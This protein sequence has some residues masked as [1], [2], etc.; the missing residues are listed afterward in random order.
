MLSITAF[1]EASGV[2]Y[3]TCDVTNDGH[4][5]SAGFIQFTTCSGSI[6]RVCEEYIKNSQ[7]T[8]FCN[9][10]MTWNADQQ[11]YSGPLPEAAQNGCGTSGEVNSLGL[12]SFCADWYAAAPD[13][14]FQSAQ[15]AVARQDY[16]LDLEE[17]YIATYGFKYPLTIAQ[18]FDTNVQLGDYGD[19]SLSAIVDMTNKLSFGYPSSDPPVDEENWL[20][21]F[22][23]QKRKVVNSISVE[24]AGT[25]GRIDVYQSML[26]DALLFQN[27]V[28][29]TS[30]GDLYTISIDSS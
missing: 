19:H 7:G 13:W 2:N 12:G 24:Y 30:L 25:T 27:Q 14:G 10:Y 6:R 21:N 3:T 20:R 18:L 29:L 28:T 22:L 8:T 11:T 5:I 1:F 15:R 23:D 4:G 9:N 16:Y 17:K 26:T